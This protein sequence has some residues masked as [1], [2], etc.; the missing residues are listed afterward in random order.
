MIKTYQFD[1]IIQENGVIMLPKHMQPLQRHHVRLIVIDLEPSRFDSVTLLTEITQKY[2]MITEEQELSIDEIYAQR[3][4]SHER[5]F[6][7]D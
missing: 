2:K 3:E 6:V 5:T 4:Q 7:F 1:S